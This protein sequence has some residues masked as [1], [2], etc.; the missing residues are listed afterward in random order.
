MQVQ[1]QQ[2][3][4]NTATVCGSSVTSALTCVMQKP[5]KV[6]SC[7]VCG[8]R[9]AGTGHGRYKDKRYCPITA[10]VAKDEW[11]LLRSNALCLSISKRASSVFNIMV[12]PAMDV[13]YATAVIKQPTCNLLPHFA[14][15]SSYSQSV[16]TLSLRFQTR[17]RLIAPL[18]RPP[19]G[20]HK[21]Q[22]LITFAYSDIFMLDA[23]K[24]YFNV[25]HTI[26][27]SRGLLFAHIKIVCT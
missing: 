11:L 12:Q 19:V 14:S 1:S 18:I 16:N 24:L 2:L 15:P 23:I 27:S 25:Q 22:M 17:Q 5:R 9:V 7:G 10:G 4:A 8:Q 26:P 6:C 3:S 13:K 20:L 21:Q